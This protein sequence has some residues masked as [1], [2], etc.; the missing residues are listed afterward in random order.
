MDSS[1]YREIEDRMKKTVDVYIDDLKSVRAGRANPSLLDKVTVDYYG[2]TT[3]LNQV[4]N[5]STPEPR[6]IAIQP[7][8]ASLISEIEKSILRSDLGLNPSNDGKI[9]RVIIPALTEERRVELTKVVRQMGES[10]KVAIRNIRRDAIDLVKKK[11]KDKEMSEDERAKAE[12]KVQEI[13]DKFIGNVDDV[14]KKKEEELM[15]I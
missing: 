7:W 1:D 10:S 3:P 12:V 5:I 6:L 15:E 2:Q 4:A 14:T 8:D 13:T 9:I 11:E